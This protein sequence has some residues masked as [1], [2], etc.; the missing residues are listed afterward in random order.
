MRM[1]KKMTLA[2]VAVAAAC[3]MVFPAAAQTLSGG[4]A[5]TEDIAVT[6]EAQEAFD[7]AMES[8]PLTGAELEPVALLATQVVAGTNYCILC[9]GR[10][11]VQKIDQVPFYAMMYIYQ[12]L[13]GNAEILDI[14]D[15]DFGIDDD[16]DDRDEADELD[17]ED[18]DDP[19]SLE[20]PDDLDYPD[21]IDD[22]DDYEDY[23]D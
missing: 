10:A 17:W 22:L 2:A 21:D 5:A 15:L 12:D 23:D 19:D 20:D 7:K 9:R 16:R 3:I 14:D 11:S 8:T 13:E 1:S 18:I 6:E 4:W